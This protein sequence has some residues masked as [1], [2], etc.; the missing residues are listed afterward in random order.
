MLLHDFYLKNV[1]KHPDKLAVKSDSG[2]LTYQALYLASQRLADYLLFEGLQKGDRVVLYMSN[3]PELCISIYAVL[4][5]GGVFVVVNPTTKKDKLCYILNDCSAFALISDRHD[6]INQSHL[7]EQLPSLQL[8]IYDRTGDPAM[9]SLETIVQESK[10]PVHHPRIISIDLAA[11]IYTSGST[12][13]PKGVTMAHYNMVS[14]AQSIITYLEN[15]SSD[16]ILNVLPLSFDYGL[17]QLLMALTFGGTL[18]LEKDFLY[19]AEIVKKLNEEKITGFAGVPTLF[20]LLFKMDLAQHDFSHLR[21]IS[22]TGAALPL[23]FIKKLGTLFPKTRIYSMYGLTECK[24]VAYLPPDDIDKKPHSVGIAMPDCEVCILD[25]DKQPVPC[26]QAGELYVRGTNVMQGYWNMPVE[27]AN[28]LVEGKHRYEKM[29]R[30]GDIFKM[31]EEGYLYFLGRKDDIIKS[32]GEKVSPKE[33]ENVLYMLDGIEEAAV[34]GVKDEILGQAV[35][36][37]VKIAPYRSLSSTDVI[38]HCSQNLENFCV[39]RYIEFVDSL[40]KSPNGKI[41]KKKI[42]EMMMVESE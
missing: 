24:R 12:G 42:L 29:L 41:D 9:I 35:K 36:A 8:I 10:T 7:R 6:G 11:L 40:P 15:T 4:L 14:A 22:N 17:Y 34:V 19:P 23:E 21:Y 20:A 16:I 28:V 27:T 18:V 31:D 39:P 25:D 1:E 30:T 3:S 2:S 33:V 13:N 38:R 5:A 32:R 26:G 37:F